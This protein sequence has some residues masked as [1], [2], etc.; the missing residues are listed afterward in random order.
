MLMQKPILIRI[1]IFIAWCVYLLI[2]ILVPQS[3]RHVL[4]MS[5]ESKNLPYFYPKESW[6]DTV[7]RWTAHPIQQ[8]IDNIRYKYAFVSLSG[9]APS[10]NISYKFSMSFA[11]PQTLQVGGLKSGFRTY[12]LLFIPSQPIIS[13]DDRLLF[14][15]E[16][17]A[18]Q[19]EVI[20]NRQLMLAVAS[21]TI[22]TT[23]NNTPSM[24][25][26]TLV[27]ALFAILL[28][29]LVDK[30]QYQYA[31]GVLLIIMF[32]LQIWSYI[33][34][35]LWEL[36]LLYLLGCVLVA[37]LYS[38]YWT[39]INV[40]IQSS[41]SHLISSLRNLTTT[42]NV[43]ILTAVIAGIYTNITSQYIAN[44]WG[45]QPSDGHFLLYLAQLVSIPT[46]LLGVYGLLLARRLPR[47]LLI[48]LAIHFVIH[49]VMYV[50]FTPGCLVIDSFNNA[51]IVRNGWIEDGYSRML[52]VLLYAFVQIVPWE[53]HAPLL[54][55]QLF[56]VIALFLVHLNLYQLKAPTWFH[57]VVFAIYLFPTFIITSLNVIRDSYFTVFGSILLLFTCW[58]LQT[59]NFSTRP[60][61]LLGFL[62][63]IVSGLR[64]DVLPVIGLLLL[65]FMYVIWRSSDS[66][67]L[68]I[69]RMGIVGTPLIGVFLSISLIPYFM[70]QTIYADDKSDKPRGNLYLIISHN[71]YTIMSL[72]TSVSWFVN[73]APEVIPED[74]RQLIDQMYPND[75]LKKEFYPF[76]PRITARYSKVNELDQTFIDNY[77]RRIALLFIMNPVT[78]VDAK[79]HLSRAIQFNLMWTNCA[80]SELTKNGYHRL[81]LPSSVQS[82]QKAVFSDYIRPSLVPTS[83]WY[84]LTAQPSSIKY[85]NIKVDHV[86]TPIRIFTQ[87]PY[88]HWW[89]IDYYFLL[90]SIMLL[91]FR[92]TPISSFL[93]ILVL[94][95]GITMLL[96]SP[97][98]TPGYHFLLLVM[99]PLLILMWVAE[100]RLSYMRYRTMGVDT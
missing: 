20:A 80:T 61:L 89:N 9:M 26:E 23:S 45:W 67:S 22:D 16:T 47:I 10:E 44:M 62:I 83:E 56:W 65:I 53:W 81:E 41:F 91:T 94:L 46:L 11:R 28:S 5:T 59:K 48:V 42:G 33:G 60:L 74:T 77:V 43:I 13:I 17:T 63:A 72:E 24:L 76:S 57:I 90:C 38:P 35:W 84:L 50:M 21:I 99:T 34:F 49:S 98:A 55:I 31:D 25:I 27:F 54:F 18:N 64:S 1:I 70:Q 37:L 58:I 40:F 79:Y 92:K 66:N 78:Y 19:L 32:T 82:I 68:R 30:K 85:D 4:D 75:I 88:A 7:F 96:L 29:I 93:A 6:D 73:M 8:S 3:A 12:N 14:S 51:F 2:G 15:I 87:M 39:K 95:R 71:F 86:Q 100:I 36:R 97:I 69:T 52:Y